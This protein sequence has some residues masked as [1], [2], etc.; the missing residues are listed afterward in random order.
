M[1]PRFSAA[2]SASRLQIDRQ[3]ETGSQGTPGDLA[4]GFEGR[5]YSRP[6][7]AP[8][9]FPSATADAEWLAAA[10]RDRGEAFLD[11][12]RG[13]FALSA[14]DPR[15][16]VD[17]AARDPI[18]N[19]YLSYRQDGGG[20]VVARQDT[21]LAAP[22]CEPD[23]LEPIRLAEFFA[24][25]E[26][27]GPET[28]FRGVRAVLPGQLLLAGPD[29]G[30]RSRRFS[31]PLEAARLRLSSWEEYVERFAELLSTAVRRAIAGA[32]RAAVWLSGGLDSS[33]IAA[34]AAR[35][36]C[37]VDALVWRLAD[38]RAKTDLPHAAEV[39]RA[40][41][42]ELHFVPCDDAVPFGDLARWPVH[43]ST[44]EQTAYRWFHQRCYRRAAE[45]GHTLVLNGFG[46]DQL[47]GNPKRWFWTLL[48]AE[49][50]GLAID[51][52]REL[53]PTLGWWPTVRSQVLSPLLP[54]RRSLRRNLP[55]Y[56]NQATR[57]L[58]SARPRWPP[59]V[60]RARRPRQA[61]RVLALLDAHGAHVERWYA[62]AFGLETRSPLRDPDLIEFM[63]A[64]PDHLLQ[65]GAETRPALRA[66]CVDLVP[67]SVRRREGK[68]RFQEVLERGLERDNLPWAP[69]LLLDPGALWRDHVEEGAV[70]RWLDGHLVDGWDRL[71]FLQCLYAELWRFHRSGGDLGALARGRT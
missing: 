59:E 38:D 58:L 70:R 16:G 27:G 24:H 17:L 1:C 22:G 5:L 42:A 48:A 41:G 53:A 65:R 12:V 49:G 68:A 7:P 30:L 63:L 26:L 20:L 56:L 44:P 61:E 9:G 6:S 13:E 54:K 35:A 25:G 52:L 34:L 46:G 71:G 2:E 10:Y 69:E 29:S 64:V 40:I 18:G 21:D 11:G 45:L 43:P 8:P 3:S 67:E 4:L 28:F 62:A 39:A 36:G 15:R 32:P 31:P 33:P 37:A 55:R 51:R 47:Y 66:A 19:G 23:A 14:H 57:D 50:P 60:L